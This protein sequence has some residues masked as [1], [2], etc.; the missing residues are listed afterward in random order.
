VNAATFPTYDTVDLFAGPGGW[1]VAAQRL[2]LREIG[3]EFDK[4]AHM[5][6]RAAGFHTIRDDVRSWGPANFPNARGLIASPPCQT[7]SA[8]GKGAGRRALDIVLAEVALMHLSH[9]EGTPYIHAAPWEDERTGLVLEPL[10]W[11]LEAIRLG[12]PY[13]WLTF[14]QVPTVLPV[15]QAMAD[16]LRAEG[17][18]V[19]VGNLQAE[20]YGVPQTRKRAVLI[21][22]YVHGFVGTEL[23]FIDLPKPTHSKYHSRNKAQLDLGVLP[24]VSMAEALGWGG[25]AQEAHQG[26]G[27]MARAGRSEFPSRPEDAPSFTITGANVDASGKQGGG[28]NL[29][30]RSNYGTGGDPAARGERAQDEPAATS[31]TIRAQGSGSHPSGTE[32]VHERPATTIVGSFKP[33]IVAAPGYRTTVSRQNAEG[34]VRVSVEEAACL[35]SF[36]AGFPWQGSRT[37]QYQQIGNAIPP[38]LAEAVLRSALGRTLPSIP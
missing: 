5:T 2:G 30:M 18:S 6:R 7:F 3:L 38:L 12:Q 20:Q 32:W 37:K 8:A 31:Y 19:A 22:H 28:G 23:E 29:Y 14:E 35:Q 17:Y 11:A 1:S 13:A 34:S 21:A 25:F 24:W 36:P 27:L 33:E 15:W 4:A 16:V 10:R 26:A 9:C